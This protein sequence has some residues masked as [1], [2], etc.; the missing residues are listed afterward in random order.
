MPWRRKMKKLALLVPESEYDRA[1]AFGPTGPIREVLESIEELEELFLVLRLSASLTVSD[2]AA[3]RI[4]GLRRDRYGFAPYVDY[5]KIVGLHG[6]S[7]GYTRSAM[8][9]R[10]ALAGIRAKEIELV[11]VVDVDSLTCAYGEYERRLCQCRVTGPT[12]HVSTR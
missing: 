4:A 5:L 8:S 12:P 2:D 1:I 3:G 11:R 7:M 9:F 10:S 6:S